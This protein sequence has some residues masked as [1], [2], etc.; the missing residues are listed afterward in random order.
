MTQQVVIIGGGTTFDT[1]EDFI[2]FLK[3]KEIKLDRLKWHKEWKDSLAEELGKTFEVLIPKMPNITNARYEQ[4][5]IWFERIIQLL[6]DGVILVGHSLGGIFLAKFF[7]ENSISK[8]IKATILVASPFDDKNLGESLG[9]FKLT[10]KLLNLSKNGGKIFLIQS[11]DDPTVPFKHVKKYQ[12]ALPGSQV[13]V[14][15][16]RG[17]FKQETFPELVALIKSLKG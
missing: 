14:F 5:K 15:T 7:S 3:N 13:M 6:N 9:S 10:K 16:D 12:K 11:K 2:F 17:H 1:N 8:I 4:W